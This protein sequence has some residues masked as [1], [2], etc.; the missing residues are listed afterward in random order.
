MFAKNALVISFQ[1]ITIAAPACKIYAC[2]MAN[3]DFKR[4][5]TQCKETFHMLWAKDD[6]FTDFT[7]SKQSRI[8][9]NMETIYNILL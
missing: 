5:E 3:I 8:T 2:N 1:V 9:N 7:I 4:L 6:P